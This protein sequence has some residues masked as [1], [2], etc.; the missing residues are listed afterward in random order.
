MKTTWILVAGL[1]FSL[2][3]CAST[4]PKSA[5]QDAPQAEAQITDEKQY[6]DYTS[7]DGEKISIAFY[8]AKEKTTQMNL[9]FADVKRGGVKKTFY[10]VNFQPDGTVL[11]TDGKDT[12]LI[13]LDNGK[14]IQIIK[15]Q[16]KKTFR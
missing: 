12:G 1:A 13:R 16:D 10:K 6:I 14:S 11:Y 7:E 15:G 9:D 2:G 5:Q 8:E 3:A 4:T